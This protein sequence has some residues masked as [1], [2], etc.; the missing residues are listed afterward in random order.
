MTVGR[1]FNALAHLIYDD[2]RDVAQVISGAESPEQDTSRAEEYFRF[3]G[4]LAFPAD[5]V[6]DRTVIQTL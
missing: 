2:M 3:V 1:G 5:Y 4:L 6:A